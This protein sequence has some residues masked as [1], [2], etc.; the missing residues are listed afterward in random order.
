MEDF[1]VVKNT[2]LEVSGSPK[3]WFATISEIKT[4]LLAGRNGK[5]GVISS[6]LESDFRKQ[7]VSFEVTHED[8][9]RHKATIRVEEIR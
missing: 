7:T 2:S 8:G 3:K 1:E 9:S 5:H 4:L 6:P